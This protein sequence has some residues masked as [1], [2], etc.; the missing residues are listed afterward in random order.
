MGN[1]ECA[2]RAHS[3]RY[4]PLY[5]AGPDEKIGIDKHA[6]QKQEQNHLQL[7][8]NFTGVLEAARDH[9]QAS[10]NSEM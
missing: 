3:T 4:C 8:T 6:K 10:T 2:K 1:N 7:T 5:I 9:S